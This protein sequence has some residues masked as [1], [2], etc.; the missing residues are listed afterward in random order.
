M[1]RPIRLRLAFEELGATW[2]K[3]GQALALR[4]DLLPP[5]YCYELS[6]LFNEVAPFPYADVKGII[7]G[8]FGR[9]VSEVYAWFD[10]EPFAAASIGQ[11]HRASLPSGE[12]VAVKV[13]RPG[14]QDRVE[15]DLRLMYRMAFLPD[16]MRL[17]G[18]TPTRDVIDEFA[19]W[20][21]EELDYVTEARNAYTIREN[22]RFD[23]IEY[24]PRV[25]LDYSTEHVLTLEYIDGI[26]VSD[27][28]TDLRRD[29]DDCIAQ[30]RKQSCDLDQVAANIVWNFLNQVYVIGIFH[31][32]LH[33]ANLLVLP[34]NRI[35]YVDFGITGRLPANVRQSL[36]LFARRLLRGD[37][38]GAMVELS[39]WVKPSTR[40]VQ[41]DA[42]AELKAL[43]EDFLFELRATQQ[44]R[45]A[46]AAA[47]QIAL[48]GAIRRH[49]MRVDPV[50]LS[51]VK[52]VI[53]MDSIT[54]ELAPTFDPVKLELRFFSALT[55]DQ[56][57]DSLRPAALVNTV[58]DYGY[59]IDRILDFVEK[60]VTEEQAIT[61]ILG[62][63][64]KWIERLALVAVFGVLAVWL[65]ERFTGHTHG[66]FQTN[67]GFIVLAVGGVFL[68]AVLRQTR[69]L[70]D[71]G[72]RGRRRRK[73]KRRRTAR[74]RN[75][76]PSERTTSAQPNGSAT[77]GSERPKAHRT[78]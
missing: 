35:G 69:K 1:P 72:A 40:T 50:I 38:D 46:L 68:F 76:W 19:S 54:S 65:A 5:S 27:V 17:F 75:G 18:G 10:P 67:V 34:G 12:R 4:F 57:Y 37:V 30:L 42:I 25:W 36:V 44:S 15:M 16:L 43:A 47:Y 58:M 51:Y 48:L 9:D 29:R 33:P 8:D 11:V 6:K 3:L 60:I 52:A 39:R 66:I 26:P 73:V 63:A 53:T 49:N 2:I 41:G 77:S 78:Q 7:R 56:V 62:S 70:P 45:Q 24:D 28:L 64:R 21:D 23:P 71:T 32:D 31:A 61:G 55:L 74:V 59:R 22:A 20:L 14:I 13:Q